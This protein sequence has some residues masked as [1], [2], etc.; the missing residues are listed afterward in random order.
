MHILASGPELQAVRFGY[1]IL[2][3]V[4][5]N[6]AVTGESGGEG[7][8]ETG[9]TE[10]TMKASRYSHPTMP[11]V[12]IW[13]LPGIG[14]SNFKAQKYL[15]EVQFETYDSFIVISTNRFKENDIM[16]AKEIQKMKKM[17]YFVRSKIDNDI[18]AEARK[19][20]REDKVLSKIRQ[21]CEENLNLIRAC[22]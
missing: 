10:T 18:R 22:P 5:L 8:A 1:V 4:T 14:T 19:D 15:K 17:F 12:Y 20:F 7:A 21:S 6:I 11:N 13:D 2:E 16:L 3:D 9:V